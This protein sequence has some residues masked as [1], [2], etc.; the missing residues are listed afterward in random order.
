[1]I[2]PRF[3]ILIDGDLRAE[4]VLLQPLLKNV[5]LG[6]HSMINQTFGELRPPDPPFAPSFFNDTRYANIVLIGGMCSRR[7]VA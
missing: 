5:G 6:H 2:C 1:M 7:L 4:T 3:C